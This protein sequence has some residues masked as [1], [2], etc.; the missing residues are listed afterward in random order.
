MNGLGDLMSTAEASRQLRVSTR[1]VQRLTA[2]GAITQVGTVGRANLLD[3]GSI[4]QL[5][6]R[7]TGRGRPWSQATIELALQGLSTGKVPSGTSVERSRTR[8]RL[9]TITAEGIVQAMRRRAVVR[10]YRSS[11]SFLD[12]VSQHVTLTGTAAIDADPTLAH[13][14]GL[15]AKAGK[16]VDGYITEK[17]ADRLIRSAHLVEDANGNVSLRVTDLRVLLQGRYASV[18]T[19]LDLAESLDVRE[20]AAGLNFLKDKLAEFR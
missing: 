9:E 10:R 16:F 1:Q 15:V 6:L 14:F 20:R 5:K 19:A 17:D 3:A 7:N 13:E 2:K 4:R 11:E 8:M 18:V 12:Q